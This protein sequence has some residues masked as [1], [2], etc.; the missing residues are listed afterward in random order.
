MEALKKAGYQY[1]EAS[2][3]READLVLRQAGNASAGFE[4]K[5]Q[6]DYDTLGEAVTGYLYEMLTEKYKFDR[7]D[8]SEDQKDDEDYEEI[9]VFTKNLDAEVIIYLIQ[10]S[11]AV[12]A[13]MWARSLCINESLHEGTIFPYV[14]AALDRNWGV[15][16]CN[17]NI[18]AT[19][20]EC[21]EYHTLKVFNKFIK[22]APAKEIVWVAHS[23][24]GWSTMYC[25]RH[26]KPADIQRIKCVAFTDS[27]HSLKNRKLSEAQIARTKNPKHTREIL[28]WKLQLIPETFDDLPA[29]V[30]S[31]LK[32][33]SRNWV[34][35]K[36]PLDTEVGIDEGVHCVSAGHK[37]H[38]WTSGT[39]FSG[40][41]KFIDS[42]FPVAP[43][44]PSAS[45]E[46]D[47]SNDPE[48]AT[49]IATAI[50]VKEKGN[51]LLEEGKY[52]AASFEYK[53]AKLYL[54]G[55]LDESGGDEVCFFFLVSCQMTLSK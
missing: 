55:V 30:M 26:F 9:P 36:L 16:V 29:D 54:K 32:K 27:V 14:R 22:N 34:Q 17:P 40:V 3:D 18:E 47:T 37:D 52:K 44:K 48:I 7:H 53:K 20:S 31:F 28:K 2:T 1:V 41:F 4:W 38:V 50:Q 46:S 39:A 25:L 13:G 51:R 33:K 21:S 19:G 6:E 42:F 23:Y 10:G 8:F 5:G 24:G 49:N 15:V 11:G 35:S 12:T 45:T 43:S